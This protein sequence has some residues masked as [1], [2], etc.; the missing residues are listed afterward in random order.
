[1]TLQH[2]K[3]Q[4][5]T[6]P[7]A[8]LSIAMVDSQFQT[9]YPNAT[10]TISANFGATS[11]NRRLLTIV[12]ATGSSM[13]NITIGGVS[14]TIHEVIQLASTGYYMYWA[15]A[16]VP[17]GTSGNIVGVDAINTEFYGGGVFAITG[18][19]SVFDNAS[20]VTVSNASSL[21][22]A[23]NSVA[24]AFHYIDSSTTPTVS[25]DA[26]LS[27]ADSP[28]GDEWGGWPLYAKGAFT[29]AQTVSY[30]CTT[31]GTTGLVRYGTSAISFKPA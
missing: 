14:S 9:T 29:T 24:A 10:K 22:V 30:T 7:P 11:A 1:M 2:H 18:A 23:A 13:S 26:G 31:G 20:G 27:A 17:D 4:V 19:E 28:V 15:S 6:P 3:W 8:S 12:M 5:I 21:D 16:E 25:W